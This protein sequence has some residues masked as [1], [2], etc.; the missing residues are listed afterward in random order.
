MDGYLTLQE[1]LET[2]RLEDFIA[3]A[4]AEGVEAADREMFEGLVGQ[5]TV[6]RPARQTSRSRARGGSAGK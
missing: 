3:Q 2:N 1:A 4:E 6:P 5:V